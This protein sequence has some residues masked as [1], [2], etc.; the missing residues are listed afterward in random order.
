[1]VNQKTNSGKSVL[2]L[3]SIFVLIFFLE[4]A[5]LTSPTS[6]ADAEA[7]EGKKVVFTFKKPKFR[8]T[9]NYHID[10]Q[11][12]LM[13]SY[14]TVAVTATSGED[15]KEY[16]SS[17]NT[18]IFPESANGTVTVRVQTHSDDISE[19]DETFK[20]VL[21]TPYVWN[22]YTE[23]WERGRVVVAQTIEQTGK[24]I[25]LW[26]PGPGYGWGGVF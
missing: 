4:V 22:R 21:H 19:G 10:Y 3:V 13:Y 11:G 26:D 18:V 1:M 7:Q 5:Y 14:K 12:R 2:S 20:L 16:G 6:A 9:D 25:D 24:I 15:Y 17:E 8:L 23:R